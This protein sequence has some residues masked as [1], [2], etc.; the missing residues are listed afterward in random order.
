MLVL[1]FASIALAEAE[2]LED[3]ENS[4]IEERDPSPLE[5]RAPK[6]KYCS[7]MIIITIKNINVLILLLINR[8]RL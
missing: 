2:P 3:S 6:C 5:E 7:L 8:F 1:I 4:S